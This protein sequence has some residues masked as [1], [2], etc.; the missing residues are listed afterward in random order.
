MRAS[1]RTSPRH[2]P[3]PVSATVEG[4]LPVPQIAPA[5][6]LKVRARRLRWVRS[7]L[8][9]GLLR[10]A[11]RLASGGRLAIALGPRL[12]SGGR[13]AIALGPRLAS[14][15]RLTVARSGVRLPCARSGTRA[16]L[17]RFE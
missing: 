10:T 13:L 12:A 14:G 6:V 9:L 8:L 17:G 3:V 1:S 4:S 11:A 15:G 2:S 5:R 7:S 16:G